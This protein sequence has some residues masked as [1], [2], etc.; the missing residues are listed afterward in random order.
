MQIFSP[1]DE[2][3]KIQAQR[4][5][6]LVESYDK[7][8]TTR[9]WKQLKKRIRISRQSRAQI[10]RLFTEFYFRNA[11]SPSQCQKLANLHLKSLF[12]IKF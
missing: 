4:V 10:N 8:F 12:V 5:K 11:I 2:D 7:I 9:F 6:Y 1:E 3:E